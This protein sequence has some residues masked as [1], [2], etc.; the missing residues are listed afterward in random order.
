MKKRGWITA[1]PIFFVATGL[2]GLVGAW[3][4]ALSI[5]VPAPPAPS[6]LTAPRQNDTQRQIVLIASPGDETRAVA[7]IAARA[8]V[9]RLPVHVVPLRT[10]D[11]PRLP[12]TRD[13]RLW[14]L[15][16]S[17]GYDDLPVVVVMDGQGRLVR[18]SKL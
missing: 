2:L 6:L 9:P 8:D 12:G 14:S 5:L 16:H 13:R 15:L 18:V 11:T 7:L 3:S 10:D 17:Y 1:D 4:I